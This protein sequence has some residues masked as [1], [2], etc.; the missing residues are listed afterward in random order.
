M[1]VW[2]QKHTQ[3][4][5][6][7]RTE[8]N[9]VGYPLMPTYMAKAGGF[10]FIVFGVTA[11]LGAVA[12][13][14]PIW[15]YG[16]YNP[17]QIGAGSQPDWY[18][19][20]LDG[21]VRM[22]PPLEAYIFGYTLSLNILIPGLIIP[23]IIFTGMALYPFIESWITGDKRE[24]HLLDRPR[25]APNRTALGAMSITFMLVTLIN[26]GNDLLAT[27]F[28]LSINQIMWFSRI[29]VIV[30]PPLAFVITKRICLSLQRADRELVLHGKETGRLVMLPHGE[31]IEVHEP[32]TPEKAYLLTQHEQLPALEAN[33]S[34]EYGVRNPKAIRAKIRSRL[35]RSQAEQIAKPTAKDVK[36]L[37]GGHH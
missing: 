17:G 20:W 2:Y 13:I 14:N 19:G 28:D 8:K 25:N 10:F 11:F 34:N 4:P 37:E 36:E 32:L 33:L 9:V 1:L 27:H 16:P 5:G 15:I 21:L 26:G 29:G 30:L 18:M 3:Y 23:G 22:A 31:F 35:S 7:G 12:S 6:P 24:H